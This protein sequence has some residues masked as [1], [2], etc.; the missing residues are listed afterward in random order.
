MSFVYNPRIKVY[1]REL[2]DYEGNT[3]TVFGGMKS[4]S[5]YASCLERQCRIR[6]RRNGCMGLDRDDDPRRIE[7]ECFMQLDQWFGLSD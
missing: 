3:T 4:Q 6:T 5:W 7:Q 2:R 1:I